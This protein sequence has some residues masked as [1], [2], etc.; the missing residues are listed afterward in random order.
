[1]EVRALLPQYR[2]EEE[3]MHLPRPKEH[4]IHHI[5][6]FIKSTF[7]ESTLDKLHELDVSNKEVFK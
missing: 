7:K 3:L 4:Q 1:M 6:H 2:V 5:L